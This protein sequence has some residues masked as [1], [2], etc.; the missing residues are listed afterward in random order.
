[1]AGPVVQSTCMISSSRGVICSL[2]RRG[3]NNLLR[4]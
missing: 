4:L 2:L 1:V 3:I